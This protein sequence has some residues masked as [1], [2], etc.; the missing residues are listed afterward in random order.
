LVLAGLFF[1]FIGFGGKFGEK[2]LT[3]KIPKCYSVT[4]GTPAIRLIRQI[5]FQ[6]G[7]NH[8]QGNIYSNIENL[9]L[10]AKLHSNKQDRAAVTFAKFDEDVAFT[11]VFFY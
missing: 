3:D 1:V 7:I 5:V 6:A 8:N 10:R 11:K 2:I 4:F 9:A